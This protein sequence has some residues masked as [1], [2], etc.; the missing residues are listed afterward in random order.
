[1]DKG[2]RNALMGAFRKLSEGLKA[3]TPKQ[4]GVNADYVSALVLELESAYARLD[5]SEPLQAADND[6]NE[7]LHDDIATLKAELN[8]SNAAN[9]SLQLQLKE[10]QA[11]LDALNLLGEIAKRTE[12][13]IDVIAAD[14]NK[15]TT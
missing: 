15:L 6:V 2:I 12:S 9:E 5:A 8:E 1:M 11:V 4:L 13:K 7:Q 14:T 10:A 3:L